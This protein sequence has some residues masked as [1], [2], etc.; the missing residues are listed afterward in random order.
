MELLQ[1]CAK[2]FVISSVTR[3]NNAF[4]EYLLPGYEAWCSDI[5]A[6]FL[7]IIPIYITL[8]WELYKMLKIK[9]F[10][11]QYFGI[12]VVDMHY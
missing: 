10:V 8:L 11:V 7:Y 2:P 6:N 3:G 9:Y 12:S 5:V 4:G 1:S